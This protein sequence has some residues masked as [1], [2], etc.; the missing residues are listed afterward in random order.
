MLVLSALTSSILLGFS[1][2]PTYACVSPHLTHGLLLFLVSGGLK[3]QPPGSGEARGSPS[4]TPLIVNHRGH[5]A[6]WVLLGASSA[7]GTWASKY[8]Q[9]THLG[10]YNMHQKACI[11]GPYTPSFFLR[12][13][14]EDEI[15]Q[16]Y[17]CFIVKS[18]VLQRKVLVTDRV[19]R[20]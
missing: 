14:I 7:Y 1:I 10:I 19:R 3:D 18:T 13:D 20:F 9:L 6:H 5:A 17:I 12:Q 4:G 8:R 11:F 15:Q 2:S 16:W